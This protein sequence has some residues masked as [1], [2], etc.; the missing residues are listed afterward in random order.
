M[1]RLDD[2]SKATSFCPQDQELQLAINADI[3][4]LLQ[5]KSVQTIYSRAMDTADA[6]AFVKQYAQKNGSD[7]RA[8]G[9]PE[10]FEEDLLAD[11]D[12]DGDYNGLLQDLSNHRTLKT[13]AAPSNSI[14]PDSPPDE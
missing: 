7:L 8:S 11:G 2:N 10:E 1:N 6:K 14:A 4:E 12:D 9:A 3:A 13:A 5:R